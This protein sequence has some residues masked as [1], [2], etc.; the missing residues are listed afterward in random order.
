MH[1][2]AI[3]KPVFQSTPGWAWRPVN[4]AAQK[5]ASLGGGGKLLTLVIV[6]TILEGA[7]RK[8]AFAGSPALRY[9]MYFSKDAVFVA[10]ALMG[11]SSMTRT[12][13][14]YAGMVLLATLILILPFGL[15]SLGNASMVGAFLSFRAYAIVPLC[16]FMAAPT[17]L[18]GKRVEQIAILLGIFAICEV[19]LGM[20]QFRMPP[21]HWL[22]HYDAS[23]VKV[24]AE[25][26]HV[27]ATGTFSYI[28][29]MVTMG[30]VAAWAGSFLFLSQTS[31]K[32][33]TFATAVI[34]AGLVCALL[35]MSRTGIL[36][37]LISTVGALLCFRRG[38]ELAIMGTLVFI[39]YMV[40]SEGLQGSQEASVYRVAMK[41]FSGADSVGH[42]TNYFFDDLYLAVTE[43][44]FGSG[45][46]IGQPGGYVSETNPNGGTR[47]IESEPGRIVQ[48]V[49]VPGLIGVFFIR[50]LPFGLILPLWRKCKNR[51]LL[52]LYAATI[53]FLFAAAMTNLAFNHTLS[54]LY[55]CIVAVVLGAAELPRRNLQVVNI[56]SP[57]S[58]FAT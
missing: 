23:S 8:W 31:V 32:R 10:A 9:G 54:S 24:G 4:R 47:G 43:Y 29:G 1:F 27:R 53:P 5:A 44:P 15:A 18:S 26:G 14:K 21:S 41:R 46:G 51:P 12:Q 33:R 34:V 58:H 28:G 56:A 30:G 45:L 49:G 19:V 36:M 50:L 2:G 48:E 25:F 11:A 52:A 55:W 17:I 35:A 13:I 22:N 7:I 40:F 38:R 3:V 20:I 39:G 57:G 6:L 16:A 37:W 42:R